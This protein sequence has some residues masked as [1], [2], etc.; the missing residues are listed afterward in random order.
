VHHHFLPHQ[1]MLDEA[2]RFGEE[3]GNSAESQ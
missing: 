2:K 1:Y 3:H